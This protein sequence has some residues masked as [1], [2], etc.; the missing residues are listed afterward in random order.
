MVKYLLFDLDNTLYSC[1][2]QINA[3]ITKRMLNFVA[4]YLGVSLD[5]AILARKQNL[6]R[7]G[8]TLE[9]LVA[10][11]NLSKD[12]VEAYFKALHPQNEAEEVPFDPNLRPFLQAINLP[13]A[14]LTNAPRE[15][16]ERILQKLNVLDLFCTINDLRS[17]NLKG[18][19]H[20]E[21]YLSALKNSNFN[22]QETLFLD[23]LPK[24]VDGFAK[25]GGRAVL[26]DS[27]NSYKD[28]QYERIKSIYELESLL[29]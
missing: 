6:P 17:N 18:K 10:E 16:A 13:K 24:Y 29:D 22:L 19:P 3:N 14:V 1:T 2:A 28:T 15:H 20:K 4:D 25:L 9:W 27:E 21:A 7:F 5:D 23:D 8:T 12:G 11:K 26:I